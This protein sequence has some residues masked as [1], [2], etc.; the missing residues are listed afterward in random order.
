MRCD[1]STTVE[2]SILVKRSFARR[3][4]FPAAVDPEILIGIPADHGFQMRV[5]PLRVLLNVAGHFDFRIEMEDVAPVV[6]RPER[7]TRNDRCAAMMREL[8]EC[9]SGAGFD[10]EEVDE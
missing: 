10:A 8:G 9:E 5:N 7:I 4:C 6:F 1:V 2:S 3:P